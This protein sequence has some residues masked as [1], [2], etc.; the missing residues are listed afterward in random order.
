MLEK[1]VF[2]VSE[3]QTF[4]LASLAFSFCGALLL[5]YF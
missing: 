2:G 1:I 5:G 4:L 3:I